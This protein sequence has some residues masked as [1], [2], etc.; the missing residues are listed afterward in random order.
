MVEKS[1]GTIISLEKNCDVSFGTAKVKKISPKL[2]D[3]G[4]PSMFVGYTKDHAGE[5]YDMLNPPSRTIYQSRDV[6]ELKQM[7]YQKE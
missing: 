3:E 7:Y 5:C 6:T 4:I 1:Q 2:A